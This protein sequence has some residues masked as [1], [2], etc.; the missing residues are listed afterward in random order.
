MPFF[1]SVLKSINRKDVLYVG[2]NSVRS[3]DAFV[4]SFL[5]NNKF[6]FIPLKGTKEVSTEYHVVANPAN[7]LIDKEGRVAYSNFMID[8]DNERTLELMFQS[9]LE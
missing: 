7:F 2:I 4:D 3:Q 1:E 6:T 5:K 8:G 9:L